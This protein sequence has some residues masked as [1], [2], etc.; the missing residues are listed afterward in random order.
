[1]EFVVILSLSSVQL[2]DTSWTAACQATLSSTVSQSLRKSM[3]TESVTLS[4]HLIL[5]CS[6]LLWPSIFP[7]ITVFSSR[8]VLHIR[9]PKYWSFSFNISPSN[10]YSTLIFLRMDWFH[11]FA[12]QRTLKRLLQHS[13][14]VSNCGAQPH[15]RT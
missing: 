14:K 10:E 4:N 1:M 5:H 15:I 11:L 7:S 6:L 8:S 13:L 12:V 3:S 9:W 2:F